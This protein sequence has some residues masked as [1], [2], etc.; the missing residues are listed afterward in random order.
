MRFTPRPSAAVISTGRTLVRRQ[1][2]STSTETLKKTPLYSLHQAHQAQ[3]VPFA[4]HLLPLHYPSQSISDSHRWV[5]THAGL[6]DVSHM[7][8]HRFSGPQVEGFLERLTPAAVKGLKEGEGVLSVLMNEQGGI[9]DDLVVSKRDAGEF[10]VVTNGA[11]REKDLAHIKEQLDIFGSSGVE[12]EVYEEQGLIAL[13]GPSAAAILAKHTTHPLHTLKFG[14]SAHIPINGH[15][16]ISIARGG[17][18]GEDG[19]ELSIPASQCVAITESFLDSSPDELRLAG[20]AARDSLRL[21][22]GMCL[23]GHDLDETITPVEAGLGW[24]VDKTRDNFLGAE[25]VLAQLKDR[26]LA[27]KRRVGL[28]VE[29]APGRE[30]AEIYETG[31]DEP[32]GRVTSGC[33]SPS[34]EKFIAMGYVKTGC[35]K[36][37][38]ELFVKVRGKMRPAK[39]TKMPFVPTKYF[40]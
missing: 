12:H 26:N 19:F 34:L 23:Y 4:D 2:A 6:F 7:V 13:Q 21:E 29:G 37:G 18:T 30:G 33:P 1:Y 38:T 25:T 35:Q 15:G 31:Q 14:H 32:I 27:T 24:V 10:Y 40:K 20:L 5:R 3:L 16:H 36:I 39:V 11:T 22:A 9:L 28:I 17:Y 8:Q